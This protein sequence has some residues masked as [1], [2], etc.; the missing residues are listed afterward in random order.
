[1]KKKNERALLLEMLEAEVK[2]FN[3]SETE[4]ER[5]KHLATI[6]KIMKSINENKNI[7][8]DRQKSI[9]EN[10]ATLIGT[11]LTVVGGVT[12]TMIWIGFEKDL[13]VSG[14]AGKEILRSTIGQ[15]FKKK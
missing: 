4:E 8:V 7:S 13:P 6:D 9:I 1:M 5:T 3:E 12:T 10:S 11:T 14:Q 2:R 15:I